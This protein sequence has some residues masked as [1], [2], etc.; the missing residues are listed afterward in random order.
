MTCLIAGRLR[1]DG[2]RAYSALGVWG[3]I[4]GWSRFDRVMLVEQTPVGRGFRSAERQAT[5]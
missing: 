4:S 2:Y 3:I 1:R 5:G